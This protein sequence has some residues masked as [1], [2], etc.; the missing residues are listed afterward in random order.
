MQYL[1]HACYL[2][3]AAF[4]GATEISN[5][6]MRLKCIASSTETGI[7]LWKCNISYV[8]VIFVSIFLCEGDGAGKGKTMIPVK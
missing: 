7:C 4:G 8:F 6:Q 1:V 5:Q 2:F 3:H